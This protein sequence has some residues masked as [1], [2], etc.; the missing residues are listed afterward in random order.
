MSVEDFTSVMASYR[1]LDKYMQQIIRRIAAHE[2]IAQG[3]EEVGSSDTN[4]ML[5]QLYTNH[6]SWTE[7]IVNNVYED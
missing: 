3:A 1:Q 7:V 5:Y 2:L 4:H 6:G